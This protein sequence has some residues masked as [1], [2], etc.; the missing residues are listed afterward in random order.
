MTGIK[1]IT[2]TAP[3]IGIVVT[4]W[5]FGLALLALFAWA[6]QWRTT[7]SV[8]TAE[9][10]SSPATAATPTSTSAPALAALIAGLEQDATSAL[11]SLQA[12]RRSDATAAMDAAYR[13]AQVGQEN[14]SGPLKTQYV[15][16]LDAIK[17]ARQALWNGNPDQAEADL[18]TAGEALD[19]AVN[20]TQTATDP[21]APP[22]AVWDQYDGA[23]LLAAD[24]RVIGEVDSI[25]NP[26]DPTVHLHIGNGTGVFGFINLGGHTTTVPLDQVVWGRRQILGNVYAVLTTTPSV[27]A[28]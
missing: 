4:M 26:A 25:D 13:L 16:T 9:S 18:T 24:G 27:A 5:V 1:T 3:K 23:Q 17:S 20:D 21:E 14:T 6:T 7:A 15:S 8:P 22:Q 28:G 19:S 2:A 10:A 11:A 12:G